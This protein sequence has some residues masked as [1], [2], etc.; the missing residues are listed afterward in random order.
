MTTES[1]EEEWELNWKWNFV[2]ADEKEKKIEQEGSKKKCRI[3]LPPCPGYPPPSPPSTSDKS[4]DAFS[5]PLLRPLLL[6]KLYPSSTPQKNVL[7]DMG[8][9]NDEDLK[10]I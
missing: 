4:G 1:S 6:G 8:C 2:R 10:A 9:E 5:F 7:V 3:K